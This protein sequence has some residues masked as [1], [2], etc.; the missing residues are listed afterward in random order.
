MKKFILPALLVLALLLASC[1]EP[2]VNPTD[3]PSELPTVTETESQTET[4]TE[5]ETQPEY[6]TIVDIAINPQFR[7]FLNERNDVVDL[8]GMNARAEQIMDQICFN[9]NGNYRGLKDV[10]QDIL[11]VASDAGFLKAGKEVHMNVKE[12][13]KSADEVKQI[14]ADFQQAVQS[15]A[16]VKGIEITA[17]LGEPEENP[18]KGEQEA[19]VCQYCQG[20]GEVTCDRCGGMATL[21]CDL[22]G[23]EGTTSGVCQHCY[24]PGNGKCGGCNGTGKCVHC[25]NTGRIGD[26][27]CNYCYGELTC[28]GCHENPGVCSFCQGSGQAS[29]AKCNRCDG[30]GQMPCDCGDGMMK[31]PKCDGTGEIK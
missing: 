8:W 5:E 11:Q 31:C 28:G 27:L 14:E 23:G 18:T 21:T 30:S 24:V 25:N 1:G 20:A 4:E 9:D 2:T 13:A 19:G 22:C 6:Q 10:M 29:D 17:V 7:L 3:L 26:E 15:F 12:S 16:T